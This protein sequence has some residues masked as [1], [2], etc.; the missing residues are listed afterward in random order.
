MQPTTPVNNMVLGRFNV[1]DGRFV[2][3]EQ[4]KC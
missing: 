4:W 2:G 1:N 3:F